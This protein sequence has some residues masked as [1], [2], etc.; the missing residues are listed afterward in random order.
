MNKQIKLFHLL[1]FKFKTNHVQTVHLILI[2]T[3]FILIFIHPAIAYLQ[4]S[5]VPFHKKKSKEP[6]VYENC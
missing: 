5:P 3:Q 4:A 2:E 6:V 1:A